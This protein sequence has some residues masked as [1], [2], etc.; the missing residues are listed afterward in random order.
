MSDTLGWA[1][2]VVT[3]AIAAVLY[4]AARYSVYRFD[5]KYGRDL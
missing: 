5:K 1:V 2:P 4:G 3:L